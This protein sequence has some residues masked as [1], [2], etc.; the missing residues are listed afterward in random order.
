MYIQIDKY[1]LSEI[2]NLYYK[3]FYPLTKFVSKKQFLSIVNKMEISKNIFSP[4][5]VYFSLNKISKKTKKIK[6]FYN[7]LFICNLLIN[8]IF[9]FTYS[10]KIELGIKIFSTN[11]INHII[12]DVCNITC[13]I[14]DT[15][16]DISDIISDN[17][18]ITS[19]VIN[20]ISN[21]TIFQILHYFVQ[22]ISVIKTYRNVI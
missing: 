4:I 19:D 7:D 5:P 1:Q 6:I 11:D 13:N 9:S 3:V 21:I 8:N 10:K 15:A 2:Y 14:A 18:T 22:E 12:S 17:S 20:T 16:S